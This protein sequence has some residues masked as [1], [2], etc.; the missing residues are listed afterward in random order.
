MNLIK[1]RFLKD[2]QP[3]GK[4]YIYDSPATVKPGD[5]VQI[6][7]TA[8]GVVVEIHVPEEEVAAFRDKVKSIVGLAESRSE[9]WEI[10]DIQGLS[11]KETRADGRYP[12]RIG[13]I[14]KKPEPIVTEQLVLEYIANAD[15]SDYSNRFLRTS[16]VVNVFERDGLMEIE[17]M[18]SIYVLKKVGGQS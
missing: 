4:A 3:I 14:C 6:N 5:I 2:G 15:G 13:R 17:T 16:R 11:T 7:K 9:R 12:L 1:V 8:T 10:V 18:N